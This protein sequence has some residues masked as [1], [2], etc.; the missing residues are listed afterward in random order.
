MGL[1]RAIAAILL[2]ERERWV[3]WL[4]VAVGAGVAIYFAL[5]MEPARWWGPALLV[6]AL[7][8]GFA[9]RDR[10][11]LLIAA[12]G[13]GAA[14]LG[15]TAAT[16]QTRRV[17]A[18][19]LA[20]PVTAT[21]LEGRVVAVE[22]T[23]TGARV[24]LDRLAFLNP[25]GGPRPERVRLRLSPR[26]AA[27]L[28]PGERVHLRATMMPPPAPAAPGAYDFARQAWFMRIGAVGYAM[29]AP[30][31][32]D[33]PPGDGWSDRIGIAIARARHALAQRVAVAAGNADGAVAADLL[34]GERGAVPGDTLQ[35]Y[36]DAGLAHVLV[37]AGMHMSMVAG[38]VF[39][40]VRGVLAAIPWVALRYPIKKWA[41]AVALVVT[42]GY[43]VISGFSVPT[44]RAFVMNAIVLLAI[45]LDREA[46]SLR[47]ITWAALVVLLTEPQALIGPSFQMSFAAVYALVSAYEAMTPRLVAWR[48]AEPLGWLSGPALY[49]GGIMLTTLVAGGA[50]AFYTAYHFNR[51]ATYGLLG[52]LLAVPVV[53]FWVM[54]AALL[55]L[56]LMPFGL[57]VWGWWLMGQG[58]DVVSRIAAL[59]SSLPGA[60]IDIRSFPAVAVAV[61]SLGA[62]WLCLWRSRWRRLG[63]VGMAAGALIAA[64][65]RPPDLL[66]D[67]SGRLAAV[68][69][70][71]GLVFAP[72]RAG[73][74][75]RE[76]W[77]QMAGQGKTAPP[78][79]PADGVRC[80][81]DGC[82]WAPPGHVVAFAR[83]A[84]A[85]IEDCRRADIVVVP[86]PMLAPCPSALLMF[87]AL[88]LHRDG[89]E[90][91]W[92]DGSG[93]P[94]TLS[95]ALW[96]GDRPWSP[97]S[98]QSR[99]TEA[100]RAGASPE[101]E[102]AGETSSGAEAPPDAPEP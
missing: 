35:A 89:G 21:E 101:A 45:L 98:P 32:L 36:R 90:M 4:P 2:A 50:T 85:T 74:Q 99:P 66:I 43:L 75:A 63:L 95:V 58:I 20:R 15:F 5:P 37:I 33:T 77:A 57:D 44:Q 76:T 70:G 25:D 97:R 61:F 62:L 26:A 28:V 17:A 48:Q 34:T 47:A 86:V 100:G 82:V 55:A 39:L 40:L 12:I 73:K 54:P 9:L 38:L 29:G 31:A 91:I 10:L 11:P 78:W 88:R 80:D 81:G 46:I 68:R 87:D 42:A 94:R 7:A 60:A 59:T 27:P 22:P 51:Y 19:V 41:A 93:P 23:E 52:N 6:P 53:G 79:S 13:L 30:T 14:A 49:L 72:G 69:S 83:R 71:A 64:L 3:L 56:L 1:Y 67:A 24:T 65:Y 16:E 92:I 18:P 8:L 102:A 84:E 96:Q